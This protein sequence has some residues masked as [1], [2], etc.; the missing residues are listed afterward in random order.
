MANLKYYAKERERFKTES[1]L[2]FTDSD[3]LKITKKLARHFKFSLSE[4]RFWGYRSGLAR[5]LT[6]IRLS[7]SPSL[8]L[9]AHELA[10]IFNKQKYGNWRHSKKL[11]KTVSRFLHYC[12][13]MSY[14]GFIPVSKN[15]ESERI[16]KTQRLTVKPKIRKPY[17]PS[18]E[19]LRKFPVRH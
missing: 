10:H 7:H 6:R 18:L 1:E 16:T 9:I 13:K 15:N 19:T 4:V 8:L 12:A 2:R 14:W 11:T 3:S 17:Y 5:S